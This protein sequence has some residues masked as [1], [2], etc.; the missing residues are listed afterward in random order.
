MEIFCLALFSLSLIASLALGLPV[1]S[2]LV[3]GYA[4]F[5]SYGLFK[6]FSFARLLAFS[7]DGVRTVSN[8]LIAFILI[9][10]LTAVWRASGS[11]AYIVYEAS[12]LAAPSLMPLFTF[13]LCSVISF[14][15]GTS[16][17][18]TATAGII[19]AT[20]AGSM[21]LPPAFIGGALLSGIYFGDRASP[22]STSA[23]LVAELTKTDLYQ[24]I[25]G[26]MKTAAIPF[27]VSCVIYLAL[28]YGEGH[29]ASAS[30]VAIFETSYALTP[31]TLLPVA[32]VLMLP[33]LR[34]PVKTTLSVSAAL[35][36]L[37]S[38]FVQDFPASEIPRL[39]L[40]GFHPADPALARLTE[41]GGILSMAEVFCIVCL[42]S[43]YAGLFH[44]T[45]FLET[46]SHR[47]RRLSETLSLF[48]ATCVISYLTAAISCSQ[49]LSSI[50]T[51][52]L[53]EEQYDDRKRFAL[54]LENTGIVLAPLIPWNIA[55]A[56]PL[57]IT[58]LPA[59]SILFAF[60][61]MLIPA[62][63]WWR[64]RRI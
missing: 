5:F 16:F 6:K 40:L 64:E 22:V 10:C 26:M 48:G 57:A 27:A 17:G 12:A 49:T 28:G 42:S 35:A 47:L 61:L 46:I 30:A 15:T 41:G 8:I 62:W 1:L 18:T 38:V 37:V 43:C 50:L 31:W 44:G 58:A 21:G 23:L 7:W 59:L 20:M 52:Q 55:A 51:H 53:M 14:L 19:C 60:Y 63:N 39:L 13:L 33:L 45:A 11:I 3:F 2:A 54:D 32:A 34:A 29:A 9:G 36:A 4:V 25:R 24:N 56:V